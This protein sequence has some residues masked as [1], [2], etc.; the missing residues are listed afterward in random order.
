MA[1]SDVL[2]EREIGVSERVSEG[3]VGGYE[4]W[5]GGDGPVAIK[6][7]KQTIIQDCNTNS[8]LGL[9]MIDLFYRD[10]CLC[11]SKLKMTRAFSLIFFSLFFFCKNRQAKQG[12]QASKAKQAKKDKA[13]KKKLNLH[14][15]CF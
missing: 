9:S 12:K 5:R 8:V 14:P 7:S 15:F 13:H 2:Q 4:G 6:N 11:M 10:R 3:R 1:L